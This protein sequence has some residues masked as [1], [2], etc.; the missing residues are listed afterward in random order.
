MGI[1]YNIFNVIRASTAWEGEKNLAPV[2]R[3]PSGAPAKK[4]MMPPGGGT[5]VPGVYKPRK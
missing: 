2:A 1:N 3:L 4:D 5:H